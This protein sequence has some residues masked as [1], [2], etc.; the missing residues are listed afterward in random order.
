[1]LPKA[2]GVGANYLVG[3]VDS[4]W[5]PLHGDKA[6]TLHLPPKIPAAIFWSLTLYDAAHSSGLENG[7]PFPSLGSR[8]KPKQEQ[9][10]STILYL[11]PK[12]PVGKTSN[13]LRTVPDKGTL[14][15][16]FGCLGESLRPVGGVYQR[17][18]PHVSHAPHRLHV[19]LGHGR[20]GRRTGNLGNRWNSPVNNAEW[21]TDYGNLASMAGAHR[22]LLK[23]VQ[24]NCFLLPSCRPA[25]HGLHQRA[26]R[27]AVGVGRNHH[28][29]R[30]LPPPKQ[31]PG[32]QSPAG[33]HL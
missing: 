4:A 18:A 11:G 2:P 27:R 28:V 25:G 20:A 26:S 16:R 15:A 29:S 9:D 30:P 32:P 8:D 5:A 13:W 3:F 6:Y 21:G 19:G 23:R 31:G 17:P 1:M 14:Q 24:D 22:A 7:Q 10:G 12:E 33:T